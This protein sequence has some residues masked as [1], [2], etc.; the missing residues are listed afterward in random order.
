[1]ERVVNQFRQASDCLAGGVSSSTRLN[2][3]LGHPLYF[4]RAQGCRLWDLDGREYIDLCCSHGA[5]LLGHGDPRVRQA[6]EAVLARGAACSYEN[7]LHTELARLLCQ[8]I[9]CFERLRFTGSG[10][11][12]TLHCIRL[13]RA[14]TGRSKLLKFEGHF[15][16]YHDQ[17]MYAIGTPPERLGPEESP[18]V[19]AGSSGL[20]AGLEENLIVLPFNQPELLK[21][22]LRRQGEEL[23]AVICEPVYYNAGCVLPE[24]GFLELLRDETRRCGALLIFDE[25]LSAFR[26]APGG[27]QQY[28]GVTPDLCTL[29][30]AVGGGFPLS[31]FGGSRDIMERLM[32]QGDCQH[33]GTYNGHPVAVAAGLAALRAYCQPGFYEHIDAVASKLASGLGELFAQHGVAARVQGLGARFGIYFG[34][35]EPVRNYRDALRHDR[36]RML[37]FVAAAIRS[38]VYFHDYGGAACHHGFCAA[39]TPKDVDEVLTRLDE[40][41]REL[42]S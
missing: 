3:A 31:V 42:R 40:A 12:A 8:T 34:F 1:M 37:R 38:G 39:M 26:M 4:D 23:A 19:Y 21:D 14:Y 24:P 17:V 36:D 13:A 32:P 11:E 6:V 10:T 27:A 16:G 33:S 15:H 35:T 7:E 9:P 41:V 25:V 2:R 20:P 30:K 29:G 18:T 5:T 22:S 28:L